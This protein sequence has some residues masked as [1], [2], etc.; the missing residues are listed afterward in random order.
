MTCAPGG[1]CWDGDC[2]LF[3]PSHGGGVFKCLECKEGPGKVEFVDGTAMCT[4]EISPQTL[5]AQ[6]PCSISDVSIPQ[7][8]PEWVTVDIRRSC[9]ML[10]E[11][12]VVK[13]KMDAEVLNDADRKE[14]CDEWK[15]NKFENNCSRAMLSNGPDL[16]LGL[17]VF[18]N[19]SRDDTPCPLSKEMISWDPTI[20]D[21]FPE[22]IEDR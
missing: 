3:A 14:I 7:E 17:D 21:E 5:S 9:P 20:T 15:W 4:R 16:C 1:Y 19:V 6:S 13:A 2:S 12:L 11:L 8:V 22:C 10:N 18:C